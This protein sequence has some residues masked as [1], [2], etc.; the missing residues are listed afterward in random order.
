MIDLIV[1]KNFPTKTDLH[2]GFTRDEFAN[3]LKMALQDSYF[4]F[5]GQIYKQLDGLSMGNPLSPVIANIF[6][7]NFETE[8]INACDDRWKPQLYRRFLDDTFILFESLE[9]SRNFFK[10]INERHINVKFT[11]ENE[12]NSQLAFLDITVSRMQN[13]FATSVYRKP[14]F[15]GKGTNFFSFIFEGYKVTAIKTLHYL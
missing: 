2:D 6:L 7:C 5:G 8:A 12:V 1:R 11:V 14:T 9:Q 3:L 15:S 4:R 10:Y 13:G